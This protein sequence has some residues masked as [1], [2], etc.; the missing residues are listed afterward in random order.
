M[1]TT[2]AVW[3]IAYRCRRPPLFLS[4][5][6]HRSAVLRPGILRERPK[7]CHILN[8]YYPPGM[9]PN[10]RPYNR[11]VPVHGTR[12]AVGYYGLNAVCAI[13]V[14]R[15]RDISSVDGPGL[16][17]AFCSFLPRTHVLERFRRQYL[18]QAE[19]RRRLLG[20][21][22][23]ADR[24]LSRWAVRPQL[25]WE[26]LSEE[27]HPTKNFGGGEGLQVDK[28][29]CRRNRRCTPYVKCHSDGKMNGETSTGWIFIIPFK[30]PCRG[31][32]S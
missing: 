5:F 25:G 32:T 27:G 11:C 8:I 7:R 19:V 3:S 20:R 17:Q 15:C 2:R 23:F 13:V 26:D 16:R 1:K 9:A 4:P 10:N 28:S 12:R 29:R 30:K 14:H 31:E 22:L 21:T 18:C 6:L 24:P